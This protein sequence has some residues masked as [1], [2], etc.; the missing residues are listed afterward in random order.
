MLSRDVPSPLSQYHEAFP[1]VVSP[2]ESTDTARVVNIDRVQLECMLTIQV[3]QQPLFEFGLGSVCYFRTTDRSV[4]EL[5]DAPRLIANP[6]EQ[7]YVWSFLKRIIAKQ[8][9]KKVIAKIFHLS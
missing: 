5:L 4:L 8:N 1:F 9:K 2:D 6:E 3:F 7:E